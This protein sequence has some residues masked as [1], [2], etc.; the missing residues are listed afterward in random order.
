MHTPEHLDPDFE[1]TV[2][3]MIRRLRGNLGNEDGD[4]DRAA[5]VILQIADMDEPPLRLLLGSYALQRAAD[6]VDKQSASDQRWATLSTSTDFP[7]N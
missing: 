5:Q 7:T 2:A 3:A 1:A 6:I 4:P